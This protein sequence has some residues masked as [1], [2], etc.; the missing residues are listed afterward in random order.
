MTTLL[1]VLMFAIASV[2]T[3][4]PNN[5]L[6]FNSALHRGL[7][8]TLPVYA[9]ICLG[10][11]L[12][13]IIVGLGLGEIFMLYPALHWVLKIIGV[14]YLLFL[15]YKIA[16]LSRTTKALSGVIPSSFFGGML[17]Q[18]INPKAW[19]IAIGGVSAYATMGANVAEIVS[20]AAVFLFVSIPC[21]GA[22]LFLGH[23][24]KSVMS[25]ERHIALVNKGMG[26]LLAISVMPIVWELFKAGMMLL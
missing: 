14:G 10:F 8:K 26:L 13:F 15:A 18:W 11:P 12:L 24:A 2:I 7:R 9:G 3:P 6:V 25:T 20:Y 23:S 4:G 17:F 5:V 21:I 1:P 16:S 22:W 19:V